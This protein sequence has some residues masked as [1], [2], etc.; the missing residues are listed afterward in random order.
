MVLKLDP[1]FPLVWRSPTSLQFGVSAPRVVLHDVTSADE[2]MIAA[3]GVGVSESG[4]AMIAASAGAPT[5]SVG[6]LVGLLAP[7]FESASPVAGGRVTIV[8]SGQTPAL[9][10]DFLRDAGVV[11][12][13]VAPDD[14]TAEPCDLAVAVGHFVLAPRL[15]GAWLRLDVVHLPVIIADDSA[16]VGPMVEPGLGP[17]LYCLQRYRTDADPAWPAIAAQLWGRV[18]AAETRRVAAEVAAIASRVVVER[19]QRAR[20]SSAHRSLHLDF[21][22]GK[23]SDLEWLPH[24]ACGCIALTAPDGA[25]VSVRAREGSGWPG[26]DRRGT[27][28]QRST[29]PRPTTGAA[30]AEPA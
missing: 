8:G 28:H 25:E 11:A 23:V 12:R 6:A 4:L 5:E 13:R 10:A 18:S 17:C 21:A 29:L 16:S 30:S 14:A 15:H 24:P 2:R 27:F 22:T 20:A 9:I 7:V 19:L 3:L 1:R 26:A